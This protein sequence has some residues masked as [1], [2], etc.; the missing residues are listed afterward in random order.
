M[1]RKVRGQQLHRQTRQVSGKITLK[2]INPRGHSGF[3]RI[4]DQDHAV[5][6]GGRCPVI[7]HVPILAVPVAVK[8]SLAVD[9][10]APKDRVAGLH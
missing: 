9:T 4:K 3:G 5:K 10:L 6:W 1:P 8:F 7:S 2:L